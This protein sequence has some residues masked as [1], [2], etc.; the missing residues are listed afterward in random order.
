MHKIWKFAKKLRGGE[1]VANVG[2]SETALSLSWPIV[3]TAR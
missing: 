2:Y 1:E 3:E